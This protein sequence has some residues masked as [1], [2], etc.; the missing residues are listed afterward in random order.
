MLFPLFVEFGQ[1][2]CCFTRRSPELR[3]HALVNVNC[4]YLCAQASRPCAFVHASSSDE[5]SLV[6][7]LDLWALQV[8]R[9]VLFCPA[10]EAVQDAGSV[11]QP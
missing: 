5:V 6:K 9:L 3:I 2:D 4:Q 11:V 8:V 10:V 7:L 1:T